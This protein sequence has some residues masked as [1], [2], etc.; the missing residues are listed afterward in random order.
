MSSPEL[1][2]GTQVGFA[3]LRFPAFCIIVNWFPYYRIVW[4]SRPKNSLKSERWIKDS[5]N[6]QNAKL[7]SI[8]KCREG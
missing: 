6:N 7:K 1:L 8:G 4:T 5:R 2:C 3:L